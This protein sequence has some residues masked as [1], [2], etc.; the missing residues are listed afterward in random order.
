M[1]AMAV[2]I[3]FAIVA[4]LFLGYVFS[5][6]WVWIAGI[7]AVTVLILWAVEPK[8]TDGDYVPFS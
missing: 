5:L 7:I 4:A 1:G 2:S 3:L 6:S 8:E